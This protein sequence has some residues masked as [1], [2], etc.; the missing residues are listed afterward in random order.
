MAPQG[1]AA[2][3]PGLTR[4]D[5]ADRVG[6]DGSLS[7]VFERRLQ[8]TVV[9]ACRWRVPLQ[10]L[11]PVALDD[12][13]A[14]VSILNPTGGLVGGDRLTID[15]TAGPG[16]H[17]CLTTPS[18]TKVYR[19]LGAPAEQVVRLTLGPDARVEW[20]PD[21]TIPFAGAALRQRLEA[22]VGEGATLVVVDA[23]AAGRVARG[24]AWR[25][26]L[27]DAALRVRD[28]RGWLLHDRL[29]LREG[30][31][32]P[33]LGFAE[34]R[35]YLATVA[36]IADAGL[37][38]F[39]DDVSALADDDTEVGAGL[40]PRRGVLVRCLAADAPALARALDGVWAT[41]RRR[42]LGLTPLAL[43]KP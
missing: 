15:V 39:V 41:A 42:V 24:E 17:A 3:G 26:A 20:V 6:R 29:V 5:A 31:P 36:V 30:T 32:G 16:A 13:A 28:A 35:P 8:R 23:F 14:V 22:E 33:G 19:T 34:G 11:A 40:L 10:V 2:T 1:L 27:L 38:G 4:A 12:P 7:L 18:A 37:A 25:F 43:R 9:A 21:H